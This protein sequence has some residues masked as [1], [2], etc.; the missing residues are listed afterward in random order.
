MKLPHFNCPIAAFV[1]FITTALHAADV[2]YLVLDIRTRQIVKQDWPNAD[3][4]IPVGSLVKPFTALAA[5]GPFPELICNGATD[6]CWLAKGHG[7][8][9]FRDALA[10]SCNAYF[11]QLAKDVDAHSLAVVAAKFG[12]PT[13][14]AETPE[15]RIGLGRDWQISPLALTRAYCELTTRASEPRVAEIL[16]GLKLA[17]ESGTAS[18]IGRGVLAKTGTA[19]CVAQRKHKGDGFTIVLTPADAPRLAI[20][21]RVHGVPGAEAAKSAAIILHQE[22]PP[23]GAGSRPAHLP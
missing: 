18:A 19:P 10:N 11:L 1:L 8:I 3:Q 20:L 21:V 16:A 2:N 22:F 12:I 17:A 5:S 14:D 13:P 9:A 15:A 6:H 23:S 7:Q 4:P